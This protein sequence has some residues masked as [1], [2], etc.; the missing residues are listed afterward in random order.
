LRVLEKT[1]DRTHGGLP[2]DERAGFIK[3]A[4]PFRCKP[5]AGR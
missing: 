5:S 2:V 4:Y 3:Q 1:T